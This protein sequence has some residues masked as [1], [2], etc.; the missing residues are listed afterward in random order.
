MTTT[1]LVIP[2]RTI[3]C[4][5][6]FGFIGAG[7]SVGGFVLGIAN[8][9]RNAVPMPWAIISYLAFW[10]YMVLLLIFPEKL[11]LAFFGTF[12]FL[13]LFLPIVGWAF[14]GVVL[15]NIHFLFRRG[16]IHS[17]PSN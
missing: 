8:S 17:V 4:G 10:P 12:P 13:Y 14:V 7:L 11:L 6:I 2:P 5:L 1:R 16:A 9:G 3:I 15:S